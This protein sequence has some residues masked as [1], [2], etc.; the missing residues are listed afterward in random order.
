MAV[1]NH[2]YTI[3]T[4]NHSVIVS[5]CEF[6]IQSAQIVTQDQLEVIA[7]S[8]SAIEDTTLLKLLCEGKSITQDGRSF[9]ERKLT[10]KIDKSGE[11]SYDRA[12]VTHTIDYYQYDPN[13]N[14]LHLPP[15]LS[16]SFMVYFLNLAI[17]DLASISKEQYTPALDHDV[18]LYN[19][20]FPGSSDTSLSVDP[21]RQ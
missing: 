8:L 13:E 21:S 16:L 9:E 5:G 4:E 18:L 11:F 19:Q 3:S 14:T 1:K 15:T 12:W 20:S 7:Q 10:I 2:D 6:K 17:A